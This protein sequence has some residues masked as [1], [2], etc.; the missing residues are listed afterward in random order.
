MTARPVSGRVLLISVFAPLLAVILAGCA[1]LPTNSDVIKDTS[2]PTANSGEDV[3]LWPAQGPSLHAD[4]Y[5]IV[6]NFLQ[7]AASD[8]PD[9]E[10]AK[11]YLTG[12]AHDTWDPKKILV[13]SSETGAVQVGASGD[14][15]AITGIAVGQVDDEGRYTAVAN[16]TSQQYYFHVSGDAKNGYRIDS[17]PPGFGIALTQEAFRQY[18]TPFNV[19]YLAA[20]N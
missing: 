20:K 3:R 9:P 7:T 18:Y 11:Q 2:Q 1:G 5:N 16:P 17:L 14:E 15:F 13:F 19:Y 12:P 6:E 4:P 10:P 8:E